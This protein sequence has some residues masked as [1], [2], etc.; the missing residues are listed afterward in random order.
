MSSFNDKFRKK[1][2]NI[3][4]VVNSHLL[5]EVWIQKHWIFVPP[6]QEKE[7]LNFLTFFMSELWALS[8]SLY[9]DWDGSHKDNFDESPRLLLAWYA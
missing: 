5:I 7:L 8:F 2:T 4:V 6:A 1:L 3:P 9:W